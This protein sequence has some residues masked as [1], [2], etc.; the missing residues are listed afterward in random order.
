MPIQDKEILP[1]SL[2]NALPNH[3]WIFI[4]S[5]NGQISTKDTSGNVES[6]GAAVGLDN[7]DNTSDVDKPVSTA[8]QAALDLKA[9][10]SSLGATAF[11]NDY[12]DLDNLPSIGTALQP[13]DNVTELVNNA[14]YVNDAQV[15]SNVDVTANSAHRVNTSNP[16][17]TS[18]TQAVAADAGTNITAAEAEE[19]SDGSITTL[20]NHRNIVD[21]TSTNRVE[22]LNGGDVQVSNYNQ[23][24]RNDTTSNDEKVLTTDASGDIKLRRVLPFFDTIEDTIGRVNNTN[25]LFTQLTLNT[26]I[27]ETGNYKIEW[28]Y[29]WSLNDGAQDFIA[30]ISVDATVIAN[31]RQ[32]PKD[33]AGT[34]INLPNTTGGTTNTGTNQRQPASGLKVVNLAAGARSITIDFAGSANGDAAAMYQSVLTIT[35]VS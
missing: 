20:H 13:G 23:S 12:N 25:T 9:D 8:Q 4:D 34:G 5:S 10:I 19:L 7:V 17:G 15:S 32:E 2:P 6:G 33:T 24:T 18:F 16:H 27:P 3:K 22:V 30:N 31:Q 11:S 29:E 26:T 14:G 28:Y 21:E 1:A 35:R